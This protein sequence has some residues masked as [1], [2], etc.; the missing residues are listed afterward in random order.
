MRRSHKPA[1]AIQVLVILLCSLPE[2]RVRAQQ[3]KEGVVVA[4]SGYGSGAH[5]LVL[6]RK[7]EVQDE[8]KLDRDQ[9]AKLD[10]I[11]G[12]RQT[13]ADP[14]KRQ[15]K[16]AQLGKAAEKILSSAQFTRFK[17]I[18]LQAYGIS[19]VTDPI[20]TKTLGITGDQLK[21]LQA[22]QS[23]FGEQLKT[24]PTREREKRFWQLQE[25]ALE[26]V[27]TLL[28]PAQRE[29]FEKMRGKPFKFDTSSASNTQRAH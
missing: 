4:R 27:M 17:E 21:G 7:K 26:K 3:E 13:V 29:R 12:R 16:N 19:A 23:G 24:L 25:E 1:F 20:V 5:S 9:R 28:T 18:S 14:K 15:E 2:N 8:L 11:A 6:L 22:I 10:E